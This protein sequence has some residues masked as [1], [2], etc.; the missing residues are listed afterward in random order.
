VKAERVEGSMIAKISEPATNDKTVTAK[1]LS[2]EKDFDSISLIE[3]INYQ[4]IYALISYSYKVI[5]RKNAQI[6]QNCVS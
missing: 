2:L 3:L 6:E 4:G 5:K 1:T